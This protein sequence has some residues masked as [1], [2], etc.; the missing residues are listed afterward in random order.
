MA[1]GVAHDHVWNAEGIPYHIRQYF[2]FCT[3]IVAWGD[4][5][6]TNPEAA[7][8]HWFTTSI[9]VCDT[10]YMNIQSEV[11]DFTHNPHSL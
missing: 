1:S 10:G 4:S 2:P 9:C 6:Q 8:I 5:H 7:L 3:W 11:Q